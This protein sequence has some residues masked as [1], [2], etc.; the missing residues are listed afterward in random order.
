[1]NL[2][3]GRALPPSSI[4]SLV[5]A[6][7]RAVFTRFSAPLPL[8]MMKK[9]IIDAVLGRLLPPENSS[10]VIARREAIIRRR[11][12]PDDTITGWNDNCRATEK[13]IQSVTPTIIAQ[14]VKRTCLG[15]E[16][17]QRPS[18]I[19]QAAHA[20]AT[21]IHVAPGKPADAGQQW[22]CGGLTPCR[23]RMRRGCLG[24]TPRL[25]LFSRCPATGAQPRGYAG[26]AFLCRPADHDYSRQV[27]RGLYTYS[28]GGLTVPAPGPMMLI[29]IGEFCEDPSASV[30]TP[31]PVM[32][33][34]ELSPPSS[35]T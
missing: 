31:S 13:Q 3:E 11:R 33:G 10:V 18:P 35:Q 14:M 22:P 28:F 20:A 7:S 9:G 1:M 2:R 29:I 25:P 24:W 30:K 15:M 32:M 21:G 4:V 6:V 12:H 34:G 23:R 16:S 19:P 5:C 17:L 26:V 27:S 8:W